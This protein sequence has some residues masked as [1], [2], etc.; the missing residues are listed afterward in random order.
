MRLVTPL[1]AITQPV[2]AMGSR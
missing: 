1:Y 2:P